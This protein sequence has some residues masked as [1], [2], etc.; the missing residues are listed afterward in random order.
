MTLWCA[1]DTLQVRGLPMETV[2]YNTGSWYYIIIVFLKNYNNFFFLIQKKKKKE[3]GNVGS[4]IERV[5]KNISVMIKDQYFFFKAGNKRMNW[6]P[7]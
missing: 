2:L 3:G 7:V 1:V 6:R 5:L 4:G